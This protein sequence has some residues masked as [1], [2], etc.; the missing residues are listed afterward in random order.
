MIHPPYQEPKAQK[1][2]PKVKALLKV[3]GTH[4]VFGVHPGE[5]VEVDMPA[6]QLNALIEGGF[7][8]PV[9]EPE[10]SAQTATEAPVQAADN[11]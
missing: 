5:L 1:G 2:P 7:L 3:Q 6:D 11:N 4:K 10:P 8:V 9:T